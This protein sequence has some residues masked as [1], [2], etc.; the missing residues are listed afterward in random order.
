MKLK[1]HSHSIEDVLLDNP[2][3]EIILD[4]EGLMLSDYQ[5]RVRKLREKYERIW[6]NIEEDRQ[7]PKPQENCWTCI[8]TALEYITGIDR[9]TILSEMGHDGS[10][11]V[12]N[13]GIDPG[14]RASF[15]DEE[16]AWWIA[17]RNLSSIEII[18]KE[19]ASKWWADSDPKYIFS[20]QFLPTREYLK[21]FLMHKKALLT[22]TSKR[23]ENQYHCV[24]WL[25]FCIIDPVDGLKKEWKDFEIWSATIRESL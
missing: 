13:S 4:L 3:A 16:V 18:T 24:A 1:I 9:E 14:R 15:S 17:K 23:F 6:K 2:K 7:S 11:I 22:V 25:G 20:A 12:Y 21:T 5:E 19:A 8:P 10:Q